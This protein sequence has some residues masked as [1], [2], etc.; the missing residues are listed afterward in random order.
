[1]QRNKK[2]MQKIKLMGKTL[3]LPD[4]QQRHITGKH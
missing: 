1:M 4:I 3:N 2:N